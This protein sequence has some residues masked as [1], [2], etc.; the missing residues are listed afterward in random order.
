M[1]YPRRAHHGSDRL[2]LSR[3]VP[4]NGVG[5]SLERQTTHRA[6]LRSEYLASVA[7][8][9][10][11]PWPRRAGKLAALLLFLAFLVMVIAFLDLS[12]EQVRYAP[13]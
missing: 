2:V 4:K 11:S 12:C 9:P 13:F 8:K 10:L 5:M 1:R 7:G 3:L 6:K